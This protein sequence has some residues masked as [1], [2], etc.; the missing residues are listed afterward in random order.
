EDEIVAAFAELARS[1]LYAEPTSA[2]AAA[3]LSILL[4][5]GVVE[6]E[7]TTVVVL[8]GTGL[9][10]TQR[11]GELTGVPRERAGGR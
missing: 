10:A 11:I 7:Q 8:T 2:I 1:G 6:P 9:K 3:A 5:Q 4:G